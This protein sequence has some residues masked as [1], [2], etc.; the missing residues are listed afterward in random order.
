M[1]QK[2]FFFTSLF[3]VLAASI[4]LMLSVYRSAHKTTMLQAE[5]YAVKTAVHISHHLFV[6]EDLPAELND[7]SWFREHKASIADLVSSFGLLNIQIFS[8]N[9]VIVFS[10]DNDSIGLSIENNVHLETALKGTSSTHVANPGYIEQKYGDKSLVPMLET[11]VPIIHPQSQDILGVFEIY[12]DYRPM[13]GHLLSAT[14]RAGATH[15]VLL[16]VFAGLFY[17]YG[18]LT[19]RLLDAQRQS[20]IRD[21]ES[22]VEERTV[23]LKQS[24][25]HVSDLLKHKDEM[26]RN[27]M[28][29]DEYKKNFMGLISHE[30]QT[31]LTVIMGYLAMMN[32]GDLGPIDQGLQDVVVTC[33]DESV[34]LEKLINN[35]LELSQLD[36]GV[37]DLS[38]EDFDLRE[39]LDEAIDNLG[40]EIRGREDDIRIEVSRDISA[41]TSDRIKILQVVQ[42]FVSNALK[43]S[44]E[45]NR[46]TIKANPGQKGLLLSVSDEG[47]G[48]P[49]S[50]VSEIFNLFYQ[51][52]ISSTRSFEGSGLGLA[53]VHKIAEVLGGR[54]WV[55]SKMGRGSTFYFEVGQFDP[56]TMPES[57]DILMD[58]DSEIEN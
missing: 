53:I 17:R 43:F 22:R 45:G 52:D 25:D 3:L 49:E 38:G 4:I 50:K 24:R 57:I 6:Q 14:L 54:T 9:R 55:E 35:I 11:Y 2:R 23:E 56:D 41:F 42:Q 32:D 26:F 48:I 44:S 13:K 34:K 39:L 8:R 27:L 36:R 47:V 29:S 37:F 10:L 15:L 18:L 28:V 58:K 19:S 33:L 51:V 31:P 1:S 7:P 20:L 21:L 46:I 30:L 12:Q 5:S 40:S 16:L